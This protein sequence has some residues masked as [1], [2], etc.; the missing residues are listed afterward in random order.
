[1]K[2]KNPNCLKY[3]IWIDQ[4][5]AIIACMN[6]EGDISTDTL[7]SGIETHVRFEGETSSKSR[8]FGATLN[9][10]KQAQ[11]KLNQQRKA[12]LKGVVAQLKKVESVVIM[13]PADTKYELHKEME[14]KKTLA[15]A[16]VEMKSADKMKLHEIKAVLKPEGPARSAPRKP[17]S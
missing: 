8:L 9:K 16:R 13:G 11:N 17:R 5:K 6:E 2:K 14:K 10:E 1:M 3:A 4:Q 12:Y 15:S 7:E